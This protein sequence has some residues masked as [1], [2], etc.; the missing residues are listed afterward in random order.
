MADCDIV[1]NKSSE[2][3]M[4]HTNTFKNGEIGIVIEWIEVNRTADD[5]KLKP[6]FKVKFS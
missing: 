4:L 2:N 6:T 3:I 5:I 1:K